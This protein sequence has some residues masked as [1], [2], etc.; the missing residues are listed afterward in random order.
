MMNTIA[1]NIFVKTN[2]M[3]KDKIE[4]NKIVSH[5]FLKLSSE[6]LTVLLLNHSTISHW[7]VSTQIFTHSHIACFQY[8]YRT[9]RILLVLCIKADFPVLSGYY[10]KLVSLTVD[11]WFLFVDFFILFFKYCLP[12]CFIGLN[13]CVLVETVP[14]A[15]K[16][17]CFLGLLL[18]GLKILYYTLYRE[19][20]IT[21]VPCKFL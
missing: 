14:F 9:L 20:V 19:K 10:A 3:S 2:L 8:G 18:L 5:L 21:E 12:T 4:N 13:L 1:I 6:P 16:S 17:R 7:S 11:K 15:F